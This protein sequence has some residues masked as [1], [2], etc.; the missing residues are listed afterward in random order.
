MNNQK[1]HVYQCKHHH[2]VKE[3]VTYI[4]LFPQN[5]NRG[6]EETTPLRTIFVSCFNLCIQGKKVAG[7]PLAQNEKCLHM[8]L[9][10]KVI[11]RNCRLGKLRNI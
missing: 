1:N 5:T 9:Q 7:H 3:V 11:D 6:R 2:L 10:E 8:F 4:P